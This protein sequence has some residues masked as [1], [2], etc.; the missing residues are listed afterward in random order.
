M[1]QAHI[2]GCLLGTAAGD[3]IGLPYEGIP[4]CRAAKLFG[5]PDRH[6]FLLRRGMVSDDTEHACMVAQALIASGADPDAF[7]RSFGWRLRWWL[8]GLP[9]GIGFATLRA[10][11]RLWIGF[12]PTRSGVFSAGNGPAMRAAIL[13]AAVDDHDLLRRLVHAATIATHTDPKAEHGA[14]AIALAARMARAREAVAPADFAMEFR[15]A[16]E[17]PD[18]ELADLVDRA[19]ESVTQG[20][21]T[22]AFAASLGL[23]DGVSGYVCHS[24]PVAIHAWL[25]H[26][27][28]F[29]A[30]V[31]TVVECGGD[32]D[33]TAAM[34][35]GIVGTAVGKAGIPDDWLGGLVDWPRS[36]SWMETLGTRL[37][38]AMQ[39]GTAA[40]PPVL[41]PWGVLPR[42]ILFL[43][44]VL[45]HGF[46]RLLPPF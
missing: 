39:S 26:P 46:R 32:T 6:R 16:L 38:A 31:M 45:L 37:A 34:A 12:P 14:L 30:A 2:I 10:I 40:R 8:L 5:P 42:N 11:L 29:R 20:H 3:A 1:A 4:R 19:A 13:G 41:P 15:S 17:D 18:S 22:K 44:V 7:L 35:G 21:D 43:V 33:T 36:V 28:D 27:R 23:A 25:A 24:V 9:A